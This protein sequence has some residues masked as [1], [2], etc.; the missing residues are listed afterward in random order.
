MHA[1]HVAPCAPP[2]RGELYRCKTLFLDDFPIFFFYP[3]GTWTHPPTSKLFLDF[4]NFFNFA[5]PLI[6]IVIWFSRRA[7]IDIQCSERYTE[8]SHIIAQGPWFGKKKTASSAKVHTIGELPS[9][10]CWIS[11]VFSVISRSRRDSVG[12]RVVAEFFRDL[13]S[14]RGSVGGG[15]VAGFFRELQLRNQICTHIKWC[16][17]VETHILL[18]YDKNSHFLRKKVFAI[19]FPQFREFSLQFR[20]TWRSRPISGDSRKFRETWQV[21]HWNDWAYQTRRHACANVSFYTLA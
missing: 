17:W 8:L 1:H 4:W 6:W 13:K 5:K 12:G 16:S 18:K 2:S 3:N 11:W 7:P 9:W 19:K 14:L 20:E 10:G 15:V 21:C